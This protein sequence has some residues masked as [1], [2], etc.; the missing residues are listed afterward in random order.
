MTTISKDYKETGDPLGRDATRFVFDRIDTVPGKAAT[1]TE[2]AVIVSRHL[3]SRTQFDRETIA[4]A[5]RHLIAEAIAA[6]YPLDNLSLD[7]SMCEVYK[8][9]REQAE[10]LPILRRIRAAAENKATVRPV[11]QP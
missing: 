9:L 4:N 5:A 1:K 3:L 11:P 6:K 8:G 10:L 2:V 7:T